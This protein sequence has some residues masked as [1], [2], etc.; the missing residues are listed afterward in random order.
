MLQNFEMD[1]ESALESYF[2][3]SIAGVSIFVTVQSNLVVE[4]IN[5]F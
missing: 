4:N 5:L 3:Q 1:D 2:D